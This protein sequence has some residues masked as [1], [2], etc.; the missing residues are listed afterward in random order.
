MK[1]GAQFYTLRDFCKD[2]ESFAQTLKRVAD[3]GYETV[4]ISGTCEYDPQWLKGELKKNGLKCV[5]THIPAQKL[6]SYPAKVAAEHDVFDCK[7]V[8]LG[9]FGFNEETEGHRYNDFIRIYRPVANTLRQNGKYFMYHNHDAEFAKHGGRLILEALAEDMSPDEMGF[10]LDTFWVQAGGGDPAQWIERLSGRVPC[11]HLK[12]FAYGRKM[13]VIGE[14]NINFDRVFEKAESAG[15]EYML[16]EQDDC[17]GEDPF[18][19]LKRSYEYLK[20]RGF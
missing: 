16:V 1:I 6:Q 3:I 14:G 5:L 19:C 7:Y 4:Q 18:D 10:T 13:A 15:T 20:S 8:G 17:N 11:I 9:S 12:D 2:T